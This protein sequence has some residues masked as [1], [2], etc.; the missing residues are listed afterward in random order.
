VTAKPALTNFRPSPPRWHRWQTRAPRAIPLPWRSWLSD[1]GSLTERLVAASG[2]DFRVQVL[3]QALRRPAREERTA[4]G[5][6]EHQVAL[7]REVL[8]RGRGEPWVY[9]RSVVPLAVLRGRYGFLHRLGNKPLGALLF[10]DSGIRRGTIEVMRRVPPPFLPNIT[11]DAPAWVRRS[12]FYL[13]RQP[14]LVAEMFL[15]GFRP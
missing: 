2:G 10:R 1:H 4:L 15:P 6:P 11:R 12:L 9:A 5:L 14:L 8:L 13:D 7:V 3:S